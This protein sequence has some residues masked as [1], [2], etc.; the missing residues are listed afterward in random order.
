NFMSQNKS[1]LIL[2]IKIARELQGT[3]AL[4]AVYEN[5]DGKEDIADREFTAGKDGAGR[6]T[7]LMRARFA[8]PTLAGFVFV[9]SA[10]LATRANRLAFGIGPTDKLKGVVGFLGR[11]AGNSR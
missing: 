11:H 3:M 2:A 8:F 7:K 9:G 6:D 10:A 1:C 4:R 5:C